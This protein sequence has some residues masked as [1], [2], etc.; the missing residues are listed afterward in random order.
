MSWFNQERIYVIRISLHLW[1]FFGFRPVCFSSPLAVDAFI[2]LAF[3]VL[4]SP[5]VQGCQVI[6]LLELH[7]LLRAT[8]R[9]FNCGETVTLQLLEVTEVFLSTHLTLIILSSL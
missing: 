9:Y 4:L 6:Y 5:R 2:S 3:V 1:F 7:R 8:F